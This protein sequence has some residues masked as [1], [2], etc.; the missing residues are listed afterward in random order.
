METSIPQ[1]PTIGQPHLQV[2]PTQVSKEVEAVVAKKPFI[3][4]SKTYTIIIGIGI[5]VLIIAAVASYLMYRSASKDA[6]NNAKM[7][8]SLSIENQRLQTRSPDPRPP[9]SYSHQ[10]P[11]EAFKKANPPAPASIGKPEEL[12]YNAIQQDVEAAQQSRASLFP[13][14][15]KNKPS[16]SGDDIISMATAPQN[17]RM[18]PND[19]DTDYER[20]LSGEKMNPRR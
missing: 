16:S 17:Q 4:I 15:E 12:S 19:Q 9:H 5:G 11:V 3:A 2:N 6:K 18:V 10:D 1:Y 8:E 13:T 7:V 20:F 14:S